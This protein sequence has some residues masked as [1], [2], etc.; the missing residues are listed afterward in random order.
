MDQQE[1]PGHN[2]WHPDIPAAFSV[3]PG[4]SFRMECLEWTDGQ[5]KNNDDPSDIRHVNL[6]RVHVLSGPVY[7]NGAEPG[8]LLVVAFW[9]LV[10]L[11]NSHGV[12]T[13]YLRK[14]MAEVS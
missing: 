8:D 14:K 1:V 7:V 9:I 6:E 10:Y 3:N 12:L 5:I 4:E 2:R 11:M 13:A